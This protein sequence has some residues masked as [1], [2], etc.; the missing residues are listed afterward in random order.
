MISINELKYL[1]S[2][3][4]Q[5]SDELSPE[6]HDCS[7]N[8]GRNF[9]PLVQSI[10]LSSIVCSCLLLVIHCPLTTVNFILIE[11]IVMLLSMN[12]KRPWLHQCM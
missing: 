8:P 7:L 11:R 3:L 10:C 5:S 12:E 2:K 4:V 6:V 1:Q 9:T